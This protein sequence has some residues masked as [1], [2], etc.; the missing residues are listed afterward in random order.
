VV[1]TSVVIAAL[2]SDITYRRLMECRATCYTLSYVLSEVARHWDRLARWRA[3]R[4]SVSPE[5][6]IEEFKGRMEAMMAKL[7]KVPEDLILPYWDEA[8]EI[9]G[10]RDSGDVPIMALALYLRDKLGARVC[11]ISTD[12]DFA[13]AVKHGFAWRKRPCDE[14][15]A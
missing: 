14:A 3:G 11:L 2:L 4:L 9:I 7:R 5:E 13:E 1:D 12:K 8:F 15:S 6:V 10:W